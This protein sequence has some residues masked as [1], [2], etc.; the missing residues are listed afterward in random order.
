MEGCF[1]GAAAD[2]DFSRSE[3]RRVREYQIYGD[4][5]GENEG[6]RFWFDEVVRILFA[7]RKSVLHDR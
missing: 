7:K 3:K 4:D 1:F 5:C 6:D 2:C